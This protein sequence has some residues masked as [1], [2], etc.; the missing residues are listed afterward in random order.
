MLAEVLD[1][2]GIALVP[3]ESADEFD[4]FFCVPATAPP[5]TAPTTTKARKAANN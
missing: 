5:T 4:R 2:S 1:P 3:A